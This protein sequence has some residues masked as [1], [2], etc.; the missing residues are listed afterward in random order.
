[1]YLIFI[2]SQYHMLSSS[3]SLDNKQNN[4]ITFSVHVLSQ[5]KLKGDQSNRKY[6]TQQYGLYINESNG[7]GKEMQQVLQ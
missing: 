2:S 7:Q 6:C 1:M 3:N 5:P 4:Y